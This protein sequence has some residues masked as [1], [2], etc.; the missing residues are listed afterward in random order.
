MGSAR[1]TL[2]LLGASGGN[3]GM[4]WLDPRGAQAPAAS[5]GAMSC[6]EMR[7]MAACSRSRCF[8]RSGDSLT[9]SAGTCAHAPLLSHMQTCPAPKRALLMPQTRHPML[10]SGSP[11]VGLLQ[12]P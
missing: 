6:A 7:A 10:F 5:L 2:P 12:G 4:L 8:A 3:L 1:W 11:K 9:C